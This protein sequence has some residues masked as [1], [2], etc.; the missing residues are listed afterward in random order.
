MPKRFPFTKGAIEALEARD[1]ESKR[2]EAEDFY[3]E[4]IRLKLKDLN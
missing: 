2:R 3:A 4:C 1:T